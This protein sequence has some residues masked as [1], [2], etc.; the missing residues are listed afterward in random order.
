MRW[1]LLRTKSV[2]WVIL[3]NFL[4]WFRSLWKLYSGNRY[5]RAH[6]LLEESNQRLAG[7]R[8]VGSMWQHCSPPLNPRSWI[9]GGPPLR[10]LVFVAAM[11]CEAAAGPIGIGAAGLAA[12]EQ[13][14]HIAMEGRL[15]AQ[16]A[17][18][19][20][21]PCRA[22]AATPSHCFL[23][24]S[25]FES[26]TLPPPP[27][28]N[29]CPHCHARPACVLTCCESHDVLLAVRAPSSS[30]VEMC[31]G[32]TRD[33]GSLAPAPQ[34]TARSHCRAHRSGVRWSGTP[35]PCS[36]ASCL[37]Q[38]ACGDSSAGGVVPHAFGSRSVD[39]VPSTCRKMRVATRPSTAASHHSPGIRFRSRS[40][41]SPTHKHTLSTRG[42]YA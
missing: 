35:G 31:R 29:G 19:S 14:A 33:P 17:A 2:N 34:A 13:A 36:L 24:L 30:I 3:S 8:L 1:D 39:A 42:A 27:P 12:A 4:T 10:A 28:N 22:K 41:E 9:R 15:A 7:R 32:H 18:Y 25:V 20:Q 11:A 5:T 37:T 38:T 16:P 23:D 26:G 21:N 40:Q 6:A